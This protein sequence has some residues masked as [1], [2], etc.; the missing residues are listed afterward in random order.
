MSEAV[1]NS[2]VHL[3]ANDCGRFILHKKAENQFKMCYD[4]ELDT[5]PEL[6]PDATSY[7]V[8]VIVC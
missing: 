2:A 8:T 1:R 7:Y 5:S 4:P 3:A 6:D